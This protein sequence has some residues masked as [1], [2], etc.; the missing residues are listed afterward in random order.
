[1]LALVSG[2]DNTCGHVVDAL[3]PQ[4]HK[5]TVLMREVGQS[6]VSQLVASQKRAVRLSAAVETTVSVFVP[7]GH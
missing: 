1:M 5:V 7:H 4:Q 2:G 6:V 3:R